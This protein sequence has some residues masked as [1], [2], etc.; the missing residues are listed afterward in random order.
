MSFLKKLFCGVIFIFGLSCCASASG[1]IDNL[2][3]YVRAKPLAESM[4]KVINFVKEVLDDPHTDVEIAIFTSALGHP[5]YDG[6]SKKENI[7]L[8]LF[9]K[10]GKMPEHIIVAKFKKNSSMRNHLISSGFY[11]KDIDGWSMV[12][13]NEQTLTRFASSELIKIT[14][15]DL[16]SDIEICPTLNRLSENL[17]V[18][19]VNK[20]LKLEDEQS[21]KRLRFALS[22]IRDEIDNIR[23]LT[24]SAN[25][26]DDETRIEC[27]IDARPGSDLGEWFSS[28]AGGTINIPQC[29]FKSLTPST[30]TFSCIDM[31]GYRAFASKLWHK[32]LKNSDLTVTDIKVQK[33]VDDLDDFGKRFNGQAV[34]YVFLD[35]SAD[36]D[37]ILLMCNGIFDDPY[38][39]RV[40]SEILPNI[41]PDWEYIDQEPLKYGKQNIYSVKFS[42]DCPVYTCACK[43]K[44]VI[45]DDMDILKEAIDNISSNKTKISLNKGCA[46]TSVIDLGSL[47]GTIDKST[48]PPDFSKFTIK[49]L[50][51]Q[52]FLSKNRY[53]GSLKVDNA[54]LKYILRT[55]EYLDMHA[56]P[57]TSSEQTE[58]QEK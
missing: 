47:L 13:E 30:A 6:I 20:I 7:G 55:L 51:Y 5:N 37:A 45:C 16:K 9:Y 23:K 44:L 49:P 56:H 34:G 3:L 12:S 57:D 10:P 35:I 50:K 8:F 38:A 28:G 58:D 14:E 18:D 26:E 29:V 25:F 46:S 48:L 17:N 54:S 52:I 42:S 15:K 32:L 22:T 40:C 39:K 21:I 41:G 11:V 43:G 1:K 27:R 19:T 31:N 4:P 36:K 53:V 24:I 33:I 2:C